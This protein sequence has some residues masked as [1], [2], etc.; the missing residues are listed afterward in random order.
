ML[1]QLKY[2]KMGWLINQCQNSHAKCNLSGLL[3]NCQ[4]GP[5]LAMVHLSGS[6]SKT[7]Y[8]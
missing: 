8:T 5:N 6:S 1:P 3:T 7:S 2:G 4:P